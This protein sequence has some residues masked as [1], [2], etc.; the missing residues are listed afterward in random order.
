[1]L[2]G[3]LQQAALKIAHLIQSLRLKQIGMPGNGLSMAGL[4]S[5]HPP[6]YQKLAQGVLA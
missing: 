4:P 1:M 2:I 6:S 5:I 3:G